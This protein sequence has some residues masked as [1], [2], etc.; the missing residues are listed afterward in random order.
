L[1]DGSEVVGESGPLLMVVKLHQSKKIEIKSELERSLQ[2][3]QI[4]EEVARIIRRIG[5]DEEWEEKSVVK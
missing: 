3:K 5:F 1:G 4:S 2:I